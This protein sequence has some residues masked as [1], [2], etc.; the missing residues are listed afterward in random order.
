MKRDE[1]LKSVGFSDKFIDSLNEFDK[2]VP[3]VQ[4]DSSLDDFQHQIKIAD[5]SGEI[6]L[7]KENDNYCSNLIVKR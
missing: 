6:L 5:A 1:I 7:K 3:V 4:F 2:T